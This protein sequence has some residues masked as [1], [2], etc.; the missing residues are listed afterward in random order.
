MANNCKMYP[1][2][3]KPCLHCE[4]C[5]AKRRPWL[6]EKATYNIRIYGEEAIVEKEKVTTLDDW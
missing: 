4:E 5:I 3:K 6:F 1:K 2:E